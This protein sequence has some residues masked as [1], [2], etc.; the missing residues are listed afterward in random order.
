MPTEKTEKPSFQP[1]GEI[2]DELIA[3]FDEWL[4][5]RKR[6]CATYIPE[7]NL[8]EIQTEEMADGYL[9]P[10]DSLKTA[11]EFTDWVWQIHGKKWGSGEVL[12]DFL[13]CLQMVI[14]E[15][16]NQSP[17]ALFVWSPE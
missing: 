9:I 15:K 6:G 16:T 10:L 1:L 14:R 5:T 7:D 2:M 13:N 4:K 3:E 17:Q 12:L 8:I 11:R